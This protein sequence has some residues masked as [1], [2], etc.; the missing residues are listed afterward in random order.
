MPRSSRLGVGRKPSKRIW[1]RFHFAD[2]Q[3]GRLIDALDASPHKDNTIVC[4]WSDHGWHLGEKQHWRKFALWEEA[5]KAPM[6]WVV[7]GVTKAGGSCDQPVDYMNVYPTLADLCGLPVSPQLEG[8]SMRSLLEDPRQTWDRARVDDVWPT[9]SCVAVQRL[10]L[11]SICRR[12]GG[13]LRPPSR[14]TGVE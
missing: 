10:P 2:T 9:E 7:P 3:V 8:V 12:H 6:I 5:T 13:A 11:H 4:L 14:S 1:Q